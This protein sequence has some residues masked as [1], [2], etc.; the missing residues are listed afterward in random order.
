MTDIPTQAPLDPQVEAIFDLLFGLKT[1]PFCGDA[2]PH[3][4]SG[5]CTFT[6]A[7]HFMAQIHCGHC[8]AT[9]TRYCGEETQQMAEVKSVIAWNSDTARTSTR[10]KLIRKVTMSAAYLLL[11]ALLASL[12]FFDGRFSA[13]ILIALS[14]SMAFGLIINVRAGL[15]DYLEAKS[16]NAELD[17][18][19][20]VNDVS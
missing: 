2:H 11:L 8:G 16:L 19:E 3:M 4:L 9:G 18:L 17:R 7:E 13:V 12:V 20:P 15:R 1:C 10:A 6:N 14:L 5:T